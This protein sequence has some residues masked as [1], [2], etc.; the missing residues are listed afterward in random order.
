[1]DIDNRGGNDNPSAKIT[2]REFLGAAAVGAAW[3]TLSSTLG[4]EPLR[5]THA[6]RAP[7]RPEQVPTFRSRP[8]LDPPPVDVT[9][10]AHGTA[11]GY[12]FLGTKKDP[13]MDHPRIAGQ[14]GL[15]I[16]DNSGRV[17][18]FRPL[19]NQ[20]Q[21][22]MDFKVQTYRSQP[23][24]TWWEGMHTGYGVGEHVILDD[25]YREVA[26]VCAGNGYEADHHEFLIT[27][28]DSALLTIYGLVPRD[29]SLLG[30]PKDGTVLEGVV[31]EVDV[32]TGEVLYEWHSLDHVS[33]EESYYEP[34]EKPE[35][36]FDYF[37]LNSVDVDHDGNL[38]VSARRTNTVYKIDH[39]T[40]E[41]VWRLGGKK[42]DFEMDPAIR[43]RPYQ[44]DARRQADGTITIFD[45]GVV[46]VD[47]QS[48]GMVLSLD[49]EAMTATLVREYEH[50]GERVSETQGNMQVL[51]N[52]NVFV[53][54]GSDPA[55][56]EFSRDGELL[57]SATL[58]PWGESYRAFRFPWNGGRP[59]EEPA[60]VAEKGT[61]AAGEVTLYVSWNG[62]TE[63]A[64]WR[65]LAGPSPDRL[66][67]LASAA[68]QGFETALTVH[69]T[70]SYVG[71]QAEDDSG[72]VLANAKPVRL[73]N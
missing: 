26:R 40:N 32:E 38:L 29:L 4:C 37:H 28:R 49:E 53:G 20:K 54:W 45:N 58:P 64:T 22:A 62:A 23:V 52:G 14:D 19:R 41:V 1:V 39:R 73:E 21:D 5:R 8:D 44:H 60:L 33:L 16:L 6:T 59:S 15:M 17:V 43:K 67:P 10:R 2:R 11:P 55:F 69:T 70:E 9:T 56:C 36:P 50:P 47:K 24:L 46:N 3:S 48:R 51:P 18:W 12:I 7:S 42:S 72:R 13:V 63:V 71:V 66:Q 30:G 68:R 57:F 65:A 34:P 61:G 35:W 25:S 27:P 31:Q